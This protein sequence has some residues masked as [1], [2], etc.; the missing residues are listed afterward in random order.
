[1]YEPVNYY[2]AGWLFDRLLPQDKAAAFLDVGCGKGRTLAMAAAYGFRDIYGIDLS[3]KLC[4][5]AE[6]IKRSLLSQYGDVHVLIQCMDARYYDV[7]ET[8]G[9]IFLFN[10]FDA[11]VMQALITKVEE[12]LH[13]KNR[14]MKILYANP[15][16]KL[17]W[18]EAGFHETASFK[19]QH[20]LKGCILERWP[21]VP[22]V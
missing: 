6:R 12:S 18:L 9:V 19:E 4:S 7:P 16:Q 3:P 5:A 14:P 8:V 17:L 2:S 10:P 1:M 13:R 21:P 11:V 22:R 20:Y 15:E